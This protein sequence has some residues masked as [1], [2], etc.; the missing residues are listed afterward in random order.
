MKPATAWL[1]RHFPYSLLVK[2]QSWYLRASVVI[3][4]SAIMYA[5]FAMPNVHKGLLAAFSFAFL[6][7]FISSFLP[8]KETKVTSLV[9]QTGALELLN[10]SSLPTFT[11][12]KRDSDIYIRFANI[13]CHAM[14]AE[15]NK[16]LIGKPIN[17]LVM[18]EDE[19]EM[20]STCLETL[21][22]DKAGENHTFYIR[23][24]GKGGSV[25]K[26][27]CLTSKIKWLNEYIGMCFLFD[28]SETENQYAEM[29]AH[30]HEGFMSTLVAGIVHDFRNVLTSIIGTAEALQFSI[31][32]DN[33]VKQLDVIIDAGERGSDTVTEL[34]Q[35]S[36]SE[37]K[38][39]S[40]INKDI[41]SDLKNI[42][43][44]LRLQ[45]P[46]HVKLHSTVD[47]DLPPVGI[48]TTQ[49]E[50]I[51]MN[52]VNN[53]SQAMDK[54][55][56]T[57]TIHVTHNTSQSNAIGA[58][59][60]QI[61]VSDNGK[62][63]AEDDLHKVTENFWTSRKSEGG[64]GL[65]LA[66]VKRIVT[67]LGGKLDITSE[68]D[69]GTQIT[70][71]FPSGIT[72]DEG[73]SSVETSTPIPNENN[74]PT[75]S[76]FKVK[77]CTILLVDD[78]PSVLHVQQ[79]LLEAMGHTIM[80]SLS[81]QE[82]IKTFEKNKDSIQMLVTDFKMPDMDGIDLAEA[83]RDI[84]SDLPLLMITA[85]GE[86]E[87]LRRAKSLN[88]TIILKPTNLAKLSKAITETQLKYPNLFS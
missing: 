84:R 5:Y 10:L 59:A 69:V 88:M 83:I 4:L 28:I 66:M 63:I 22:S 3:F 65:G 32:D 78:Q 42:F 45:L 68:L 18:I 44:L 74:A 61:T 73:S 71:L 48:T 80:T 56:G 82:A 43:S 55:R 7:I 86:T 35:I 70:L 14:L 54:D 21:E 85:Y 19:E 24:R 38:K 46:V 40:P 33:A 51:L 77:P 50:Q 1:L 16:S 27:L 17:R 37:Y 87:K 62:G 30:V 57:I 47:K 29:Q 15:D 8:R 67:N 41:I 12:E 31:K 39:S 79:M 81:G 34:L 11:Y 25:I 53:A 6:L 76:S 75:S 60:L 36:S 2:K 20:M 52:L 58:E 72:N 64:T 13:A 49:L 23:S 9:T 26:L